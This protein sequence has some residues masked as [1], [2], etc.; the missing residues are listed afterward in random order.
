MQESFQT[1]SRSLNKK[2]GAET[3][4]ASKAAY[5]CSHCMQSFSAAKLEASSQQC[6]A[7][8]RGSLAGIRTAQPHK[9]SLSPREC[10]QLCWGLLCQIYDACTNHTPRRCSGAVS[11]CGAGSSSRVSSGG[12]NQPGLPIRSSSSTRLCAHEQP[13]PTRAGSHDLRY[14][15]S[16]RC[17]ARVMRSHM[18]TVCSARSPAEGRRRWLA[19]L[20]SASSSDRNGHG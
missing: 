17:C 11:C 10:H 16:P 19:G 4:V 6:L 2:R 9:L 14:V 12:A 13:R 8:L 15:T 7:N 1:S 18:L 20:V 3:S 5:R